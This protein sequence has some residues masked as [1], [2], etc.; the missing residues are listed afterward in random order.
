MLKGW[1]KGKD[2]ADYW[3]RMKDWTTE[4]E[5]IQTPEGKAASIKKKIFEK[6]I[7]NQKKRRAKKMLKGKL[8]KKQTTPT[9]VIS[10][11]MQS[12]PLQKKKMQTALLHPRIT[13]QIRGNLASFRIY[14]KANFKSKFQNDTSNKGKQKKRLNKKKKN[15]TFDWRTDQIIFRDDELDI[16]DLVLARWNGNRV[17][18]PAMIVG[19]HFNDFVSQFTGKY[20]GNPYRTFDLKFQEDQLMGYRVPLGDISEVSQIKATQEQ[21][22]YRQSNFY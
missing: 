22:S 14:A 19:I 18:F 10:T 21:C 6:D 20:V 1:R 7:D 13:A 17:A 11:A 9:T 4:Q 16:G 2:M 5:Y 3:K 8:S 12:N 15:L